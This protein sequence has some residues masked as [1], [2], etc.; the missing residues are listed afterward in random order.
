MRPVK[1]VM[2]AFGPYAGREAIDFDGAIRP[3]NQ[4]LSAGP[5]AV[6]ATAQMILSLGDRNFTFNNINSISCS[7]WPFD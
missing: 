2:S 5:I 7:R 4:T 6:G 3:D 1:L